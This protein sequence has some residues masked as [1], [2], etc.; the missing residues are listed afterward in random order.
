MPKA[1]ISEFIQEKAGCNCAAATSKAYSKFKGD[2][3]KI[4]ALKEKADA[5]ASKSETEAQKQAGIARRCLAAEQLLSGDAKARRSKLREHIKKEVSIV[6]RQYAEKAKQLSKQCSD[7]IAMARK[8]EAAKS[9]TRVDAAVKKVQL[10]MKKEI[11]Q[12]AAQKASFKLKAKRMKLRLK[13]ELDNVQK[14]VSA[15]KKK[16]LQA[17]EAL[18]KATRTIK[19]LEQK[20]KREA[21][22]AKQKLDAVKAQLAAKIKENKSAAKATAIARGQAKKASQQTSHAQLAAKA[23][24]TAEHVQV[25][26]LKNKLGRAGAKGKAEGATIRKDKVKLA[27]EK[28][29]LHEA[30]DKDKRL[31]AKVAKQGQKAQLAKDK[32]A[33]KQKRLGARVARLRA[34]K[35]KASK[36][37]KAEQ[38]ALAGAKAKAVAQQAK[39]AIAEGQT[40]GQLT[41]VLGKLKGD[42]ATIGELRKEMVALRK[43]K[44][45]G[46]GVALKAKLVEQ[47]VKASQKEAS[48]ELTRARA[49]EKLLGLKVKELAKRKNGYKARLIA[50]GKLMDKKVATAKTELKVCMARSV[51][52]QKQIAACIGAEKALK[53]EEL[54]MQALTKL[55]KEKLA[56]ALRKR[57][58]Q[59]AICQ[60]K[61][62]GLERHLQDKMVLKTKLESTERVLK[63]WKTTGKALQGQV[64]RLTLQRNQEMLKQQRVAMKLTSAHKQLARA[65][66]KVNGLSNEQKALLAKK[67]SLMMAEHSIRAKD[68]V[69]LAKEDQHLQVCRL[70]VRKLIGSL[71]VSAL[72]LGAL[73]VAYQAGKGKASR[74][75]S[76]VDV[77]LR[78]CEAKSRLKIDL[79]RK[80]QHA[81]EALAGSA[82]ARL[83]A[84]VKFRGKSE[85]LMKHM[86]TAEAKFQ[87]EHKLLKQD[88]EKLR[89]TM[90]INGGLTTALADKQRKQKLAAAQAKSMAKGLKICEHVAK[91]IEER[92]K[93]QLRK[94]NRSYSRLLATWNKYKSK[95]K[96]LMICEKIAAATRVKSSVCA[97]KLAGTKKQLVACIGAENMLKKEGVS[98]AALRKMTKTEL[99][100]RV[101]VR[102]KQV[103]TC[104][105][106]VAS[107]NGQVLE[108]KK[109]QA[110]MAHMKSKFKGV[111]SYLKANANKWKKKDVL[112][113]LEEKK[114]G[115]QARAMARG[116]SRAERKITRR[117]E[118][119]KKANTDT[120][121][122][123][124]ALEAKSKLLRAYKRA[125]REKLRK[126][127]KV[128]WSKAQGNNKVWLR[129]ALKKC[130]GSEIGL[131]N[132][133]VK[134]SHKAKMGLELCRRAGKVALT[135]EKNRCARMQ[136]RSALAKRAGKVALDMCKRTSKRLET[137][138]ALAARAGK[139]ALNMCISKKTMY[140]E[141]AEKCPQ[142]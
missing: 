7:K 19:R 2:M 54:S 61:A 97:A 87:K 104:R 123:K 75:I 37:A 28:A 126:I 83:R 140:K 30:L 129:K 71:R 29:Q 88:E 98:M 12:F 99:L 137:R 130:H 10:R 41:V 102:R 64:H 128:L 9:G 142:N 117:N 8:D 53:R 59:L 90:Q 122:A 25:V 101:E 1:G 79:C 16:Q 131:H 76:R 50:K 68:K 22:L 124:S 24:E 118:E 38:V 135:M 89:K 132:K 133:W 106:Q 39:D 121:E 14:K 107:L 13:V 111:A 74:Q 35:N 67:H 92:Y 70:K 17:E 31:A 42:K 46:K 113:K 26:K 94:R 86:A 82:R 57:R 84:C 47:E 55:S 78:K 45:G 4:T 139:V 33:D 65:G 5:R 100:K 15:A 69:M 20:M 114:A 6:E 134:C 80:K 119:L 85:L 44:A 49:K 21:V 36:K 34:A 73:K 127:K 136:T 58:K 62:T 112:E 108:G 52:Y 48:K 120:A 125:M 141:Q 93:S 116:L 23:A 91:S 27:K 103:A 66:I 56:S 3:K 96:G 110:Q 51:G 40:K 32:A 81:A 63:E 95:N 72:K 138:A 109:C 115:A 18:K 43:K 60:A 11:D 105:V 77:R